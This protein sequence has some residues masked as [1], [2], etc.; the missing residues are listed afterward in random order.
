MNTAQR[1][2][3]R[4]WRCST[5]LSGKSRWFCAPARVSGAAALAL[6]ITQ[7]AKRC[8]GENRRCSAKLSGKSRQ[9]CAAAPESGTAAL[10]P[11]DFP[12]GLALQRQIPALQRYALWIFQRA[13]W[14]SAAA[15]DSSAA[16]LHQ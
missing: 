3:A 9:H 16:A 8:S 12:V 13:Y 11:L 2:R 7:L 5:Q 14:W 4:F 10:S 15:P 1:C 6:W